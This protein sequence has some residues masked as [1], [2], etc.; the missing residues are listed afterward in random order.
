MIDIG[1]K[2]PHVHK[3]PNA[4]D[5][6]VKPPSSSSV[7]ALNQLIRPGEGLSTSLGAN[8]NNT[9]FG[10]DSL[11]AA[12]EL[13]S[14]D[15]KVTHDV[16]LKLAS[17]QGTENSRLSDEA[18]G[19]IHHEHRNFQTWQTESKMA[20][21]AFQLVSYAWGGNSKEM[22]TYFSLDSTPLFILL[23]TDFAKEKPEILGEKVTRNDDQEITIKQSL[24]DATQWVTE[25]IDDSGLVKIGRR[26]IT[27]LLHQTWKD[28]P[29]GYI[30]DDGKM[31]NIFKPIAYLDIQALAANSLTAAAEL[32]NESGSGQAEK[33]QN[34][35]DTIV[36]NTTDKFWMEDQQF[37]A[38]AINIDEYGKQQR[39]QTIQSDGGRI[40]NTNFFDN[41]PEAD[42]VKYVTGITKKL[43]SNDFLT[44]AGIRSR[45]LQYAD[46][47]DVADYHGALVSWPIDTYL[48]AKGLRKQELPKLAEQLESRMLNAVHMSGNNYEFFYVTSEGEVLLDPEAAKQKRPGAKNI[49]VQMY[50]DS[51]AAWTVAAVHAIESSNKQSN[52]DS[53]K[54]TWQSQLEEE[55]LSSIKNV[56]V[57]K[58]SMPEQPNVYLDTKEG[59][60]RTTIN[61]IKGL[62][63]L[64]LRHYLLGDKK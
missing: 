51:N 16:I 59:R 38:S 5:K 29:T 10:R 19:R 6:E 41:L 26:N 30:K 50:P 46:K 48:T 27:G 43:F 52:T 62:G 64:A 63:S 44:D 35:A 17:L 60:G 12:R 3:T 9:I 47:S 11:I 56:S 45:A 13:H 58:S 23:V 37:F 53:D 39:L 15:P 61:L 42:R 40:L 8:F 25:H 14:Y 33:W 36:K 20:K 2:R 55:I 4:T 54:E 57:N 49:P 34:A 21:I 28:S 1:T 7:E 22:T 32:I 31:A 18:P 24:I